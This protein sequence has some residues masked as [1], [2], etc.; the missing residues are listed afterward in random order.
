M[1]K[2][3]W[4]SE[5]DSKVYSLAGQL[6]YNA[7]TSADVTNY[8]VL[9]PKN[10]LEL[11]AWLE[12]SRFLNPVFRE[13]YIERKVIQEERR[14]RYDSKPDSALYELFIKTAFGISPYGKPVIGFESNIPRLKW[15]GTQD[16]F[17]KKYIPSKNG[18]YNSR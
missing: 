3:S 12:S 6:G 7:Y 13:F 14:M 9:L 1:Y 2:G 16:F 4:I 15:S 10:R 17:Y 5:E 18:Y 11:W 8:Q